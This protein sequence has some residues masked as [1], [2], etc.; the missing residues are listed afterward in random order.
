MRRG[1]NG[2]RSGRPDWVA[3]WLRADAAE[4]RPAD[5]PPVGQCL[6]DERGAQQHREQ[7]DPDRRHGK[8]SADPVKRQHRLSTPEGAV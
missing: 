3:L 7:A 5:H 1:G 4:A 6:P 2:G 8:V